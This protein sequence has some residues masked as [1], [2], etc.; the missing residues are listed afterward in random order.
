MVCE[1]ES[2]ISVRVCGCV[3]VCVVIDRTAI[4][5]VWWVELELVSGGEDAV[6]ELF[7]CEL[8]L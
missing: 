7:Q 1:R 2:I 4:L 8:V 6:M 3:W 5:K